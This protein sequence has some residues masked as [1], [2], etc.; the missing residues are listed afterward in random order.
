MLGPNLFS[1]AVCGSCGLGFNHK[2]GKSNATAIGI[3]LAVSF[4]VAILVLVSVAAR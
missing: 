4:G 2:T 3:Y 1:H